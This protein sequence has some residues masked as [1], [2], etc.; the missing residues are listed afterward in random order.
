M[1]E[2]QGWVLERRSSGHWKGTPPDRTKS[3]VHFSESSEPRAFRNTLAD[4]R[5]QGFIWEEEKPSSKRSV[6]SL[7]T[8][9]P[10]DEVKTEIDRH[11]IALELPEPPPPPVS[12]PQEMDLDAVFARL[13]EAKAYASLADDHLRECEATLVAAQRALAEAKEER[14]VARQR[15]LDAKETFD[16]RFF[17]TPEADDEDDEAVA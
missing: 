17:E 8:A 3:I 6:P 10:F 15:L 13:K 9:L 4:L 5:K 7:A 11:L 14:D 2:A 16:R 1:L 12:A